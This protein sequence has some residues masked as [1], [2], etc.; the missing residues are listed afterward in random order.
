[1]ALTSD[2]EV[3]VNQ[4]V[5]S[6]EFPSAGVVVEEGLRLLKARDQEGITARAHAARVRGKW[7]RNRNDRASGMTFAAKFIQAS[8]NRGTP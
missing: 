2:L 8:K 7:S 6:G 4:K 1:M 5:R 3:L